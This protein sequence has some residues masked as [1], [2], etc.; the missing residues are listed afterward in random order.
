MCCN[1][2]Q[3]CYFRPCVWT[4]LTRAV[5]WGDAF[6]LVHHFCGILTTTARFTNQRTNRIW[7]PTCSITALAFFECLAFNWASC[8]WFECE[9]QPESAF[10]SQKHIVNAVN[11][12]LFPF[13]LVSL[14]TLT[15]TFIWGD[16]F[17]LVY[18]ICGILTATARFTDQ[19][20]NRIWVPTCS[21]TSFA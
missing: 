12:N 11:H 2:P 8:K 1:D 21:I 4:T 20:T 10:I 15:R 16:A 13:H 9:E 7:V 6:A 14:T 3:S 18:H 19:R 17:A 5:I